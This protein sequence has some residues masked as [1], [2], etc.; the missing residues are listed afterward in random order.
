MGGRAEI[1]KS[2]M[3]N[4]LGAVH[5]LDHV[6]WGA[7]GVAFVRTYMTVQCG[8][9]ASFCVLHVVGKLTWRVVSTGVVHTPIWHN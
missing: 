9:M 1:V 5:N 7:S 8:P 3:G 6:S 2:S 4:H